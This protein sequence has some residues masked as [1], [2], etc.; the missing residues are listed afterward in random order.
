MTNGLTLLFHV[1][2]RI[3]FK[4]L[5]LGSVNSKLGIK[6]RRHSTLFEITMSDQVLESYTSLLH[7]FDQLVGSC[8]DCLN[9]YSLE[10]IDANLVKVEKCL[11]DRQ[12]RTKEVTTNCKDLYQSYE[13]CML[14]NPDQCVQPLAHLF[15][16]AR[17]TLSP[18]PDQQ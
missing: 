5:K 13:N 8:S 16:C 3:T 10:P 1:K 9:N 18:L 15:A 11:L 4:L 6:F 2:K 17:E 7:N 12:E 14:K